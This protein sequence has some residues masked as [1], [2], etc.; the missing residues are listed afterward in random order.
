MAQVQSYGSVTWVKSDCT[1]SQRKPRGLSLVKPVFTFGRLS[2]NDCRM[3]FETCSKVHATITVDTDA[4]YEAVIGCSGVNGLF[5]NGR[6]INKGESA[7]LN[8]GDLIVIC[9]R[10]FKWGTATLIDVKIDTPVRPNIAT[11]SP[12]LSLVWPCE[13]TTPSSPYRAVSLLSGLL[14]PFRSSAPA[15]P[16][17]QQS[18]SPTP[19]YLVHTDLAQWDQMDEEAGDLVTWEEEE[20]EVEE[21]EDQPE[22]TSDAPFALQATPSLDQRARSLNSPISADRRTTHSPNA[23]NERRLSMRMTIVP[24]DQAEEW[25][26]E[27]QE[28]LE[29]AKAKAEAAQEEWRPISS[30]PSPRRTEAPTTPTR[31]SSSTS[32]RISS[33][34]LSSAVGEAAASATLEPS[35]NEEGGNASDSD[36]SDDEAAEADEDAPQP[37]PLTPTFSLA[38]TV[39]LPA[40]PADSPTSTPMIPRHSLTRRHSL[41]EKVL[42][43]S[44]IKSVI[45]PPL[46]PSQT[47]GTSSKEASKEGEHS[48][49]T[50]SE[51]S[52]PS[53]VELG[54][55]LSPAKTPRDSLDLVRGRNGLL[56]T[57]NRENVED[58]AM[59][60]DEVE[61]EVASQPMIVPSTPVQMITIPRL[62]PTSADA[63]QAALVPLPE[64]PS[65][66]TYSYTPQSTRPI[67]MPQLQHVKTTT[68]TS[69]SSPASNPIAT[70]SAPRT[71][72]TQTTTTTTANKFSGFVY[73]S[74]PSRSTP[75]VAAAPRFEIRPNF[76][77]EM[78]SPINH[79]RV[80]ATPKSALRPMVM[81]G[82]RKSIKGFLQA[83]P[84]TVKRRV[85]FNDSVFVKEIVDI[86]EPG[87]HWRDGDAEEER[88]VA[89]AATVTAVDPTTIPLP[90]SP[91][92]PST[93]APVLVRKAP[94]G[95]L[96]P[97]ESMKAA[98]AQLAPS[99]PV[100]G[101]PYTFTISQPRRI[102]GLP[103]STKAIRLFT[104][105]GTPM[106]RAQRVGGTPGMGSAIKVGKAARVGGT[107]SAMPM[108][109]REEGSGKVA[110][111]TTTSST[112]ALQQRMENLR[113]PI[114]NGSSNGAT[115]PSAGTPYRPGSP[116]RFG[117]TTESITAPKSVKSTSTT[118]KPI[119]STD[120]DDL[121]FTTPTRPA[122]GYQQAPL[123]VGETT[124]NHSTSLKRLFAPRAPSAITPKMNGLRMMFK[125]PASSTTMNGEGVVKTPGFEGLKELLLTPAAAV[126]G[127]SGTPVVEK[128]VAE[129]APEV[130]E[131][132]QAV[133]TV[134]VVEPIIKVPVVEAVQESL[135]ESPVEQVDTSSIEPHLTEAIPESIAIAAPVE[136][137]EIATPEPAVVVVV[138]SE[139]SE[140]EVVAA[141]VEQVNKVFETLTTT[142]AP[143]KATRAKRAPVAVVEDV[144][145]AAEIPVVETTAKEVVSEKPAR[146]SRAKKATT[147]TAKKTVT[148]RKAASV[149]VE[150]ETQAPAVAE[151]K[152]TRGRGKKV[153]EPEIEVEAPVEVVVEEPPVEVVKPKRSTASKKKVAAVEVVSEEIQA[154]PLPKS[155]PVVRKGRGTKAAP[156]VFHEDEPDPVPEPV[157]VEPKVV[158]KARSRSALKQTESTPQEQEGEVPVPVVVKPTRGRKAAVVVDT[159]NLAPVETKTT[160]RRTAAA[161]KTVEPVAETTT[162]TTT[163][164][165]RTRALRTRK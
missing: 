17:A 133:E 24:T 29:M 21:E 49:E 143:K 149:V 81:S 12:R 8:H 119:E 146:A 130:V 84:S 58:D 6:L 120:D 122:P 75:I 54:P 110:P 148:T 76:T 87:L 106:R 20:E 154:E 63:R 72:E 94:L 34:L 97:S 118:T 144:V 7:N 83:P 129:E 105:N 26:K 65:G 102:G 16:I 30:T 33:F 103:S 47:S 57:P 74:T 70:A 113:S 64:T 141:P 4:P 92:A 142:T 123:V 160:K 82:R 109:G 159:E 35:D 136:P 78:T 43:R 125:T 13:E 36:S 39:P 42:I 59:D 56:S 135:P 71:P 52:T 155:K 31:R 115:T 15:S 165:T 50:R 60:V 22:A 51:E 89:K 25:I 138:E 61:I 2:S 11:S 90:P 121:E 147:A 162:T 134:E 44:A 158:R 32:R 112:L 131:V 67:F 152:T 48:E 3:A 145:A 53:K 55:T 45:T 27:R 73:H 99:G 137:V 79:H 161:V 5:L 124:P 101:T 46:T 107:P 95:G 62:V 38:T 93:P 153:Q 126:T 23:R 88:A 41:R 156:L 127:K 117:T 132:V 80:M 85:V 96:T 104:S 69:T 1:K 114:E 37:F 9:D 116:I 66:S 19:F 14:S 108:L 86:R 163:T 128:V 10:T 77:P 111:A 18:L 150:D 157:A 139:A 68:P 28:K 98:L 40:S 91:T 164:T 100:F 151:K 140:P